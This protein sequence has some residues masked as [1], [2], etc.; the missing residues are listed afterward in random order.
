M[1]FRSFSTASALVVA[2]ASQPLASAQFYDSGCS[3]CGTA[4][5]VAPPIHSMASCAQVTSCTPV[6]PVQQ[7]CYQTVPVTTYRQEKQT[8]EVPTYET[9]YED[10]Q[11]TVYEPVSRQRTVEVPTVSYQNVT[12]NRVVHRDMGRWQTNYTPV[13]KCA[14][15][16]VDPRPGFMGWLN[17]TGYSF[18]SAFTPNYRTSRQYVPKMMACNVATTRQVAVRGTKQVVVNETHMV[19]KV[20]TERVAVQKL[21][22]KKQTVMVNKPVTAYRT[23]PI[24]TS[25][26]YGYGGYGGYAGGATTAWIV[27]DA[28]TSRVANRPEPDPAFGE[29]RSAFQED[30]KAPARNGDREFKRSDADDDGRFQRSSRS[31]TLPPPIEDE[32]LSKPPKTFPADSIAPPSF[33]ASLDRPRNEVVRSSYSRSNSSRSG[34][35]AASQPRVSQPKANATVRIGGWKASRS[36]SE[37][38][39]TASSNERSAPQTTVALDD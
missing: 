16:Q 31:R 9:A 19:A 17:R 3:S 1:L 32:P 21:V 10:R 6:Q 13:A 20:K 8:V 29:T 39:R 2:L 23:V 4:A 36:S 26:A 35:T 37:S 34:R 11:V 15:C 27:D 14:P 18:R 25:M 24:G 33:G 28:D 7:V 5:A 12:E 30:G 22:M 38:S